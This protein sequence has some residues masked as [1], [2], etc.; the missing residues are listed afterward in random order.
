MANPRAD[1]GVGAGVPID[2]AD[3]RRDGAVFDRS[4]DLGD[5]L[6]LGNRQKFFFARQRITH[7]LFRDRRE[8]S[9]QRF[10]LG[11]KLGAV[12]AAD[13]RHAHANAIHG[14][15]KSSGNFR[16]DIRR[17][18]TRCPNV[19]AI[20]LV[21]IRQGHMRLHR[22]M[23]RRRRAER[24]LEY[25]VSLGEGL[26]DVAGTELEMIAD[27]RLLPGFDVR[28]IGESLGRLMLLMHQGR[29]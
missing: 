12:T 27:I 6:V 23:L 19:Q 1:L 9:H 21:E 18:L 16:P 8:H 7:R 24:V 29:S 5:D 4:F 28:E 2:F 17:R 13:V 15:A 20:M 22:H 14:N 26:L 25:S 10:E 3:P 11:I